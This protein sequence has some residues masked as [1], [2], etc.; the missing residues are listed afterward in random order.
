MQH[1][2]CAD[3]MEMLGRL[4]LMRRKQGQ[5]EEMWK[6]YIVGMDAIERALG[7]SY[8]EWEVGS[9]VFFWRWARPYRKEMCDGMKVWCYED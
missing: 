5:L 7:A 8:W 6:D 2:Y 9:T 3:W 1:E 4:K